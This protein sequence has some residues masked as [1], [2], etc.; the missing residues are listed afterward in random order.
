[1]ERRTLGRTGI[2]VS[3]AGLGCGGYSRLGMARGGTPGEAQAVVSEAL[4]L[5]INFFDTARAYGTEEVVGKAVAGCRESVVIS[6]KTLFRDRD[7]RYMPADRLVAS[8]E[9][10]LARLQ[11]DY[12]DVYSLHGVTPEHLDACL[13]QFVP[14]LQEQ[15]RL[16]KIRHLGVTESF[17]NDPAHEMLQRAIPTGLFDVVMVGFNFL[18]ASARESV[19]KLA[20][21]HG[22]GTQ[23]MHAVRRALVDLGTLAETLDKLVE[24][25]EIDA[26]RIN[27]ADPIDFLRD[28]EG[29]QSLTEAAYR[30][31]RHEPG[32]SVVL[33]GTGSRDHLRDNTAAINGAELPCN[34][35][36]KLQQVFSGVKSASGD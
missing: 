26:S 25:G 35:R 20:Q 23:V 36:Q 15:V 4:D 12:V 14:T 31:C 13:E 27:P 11:T 33:T 8:L 19:F 32:V 34:L 22:V 29:V 2:E 6:T 1:M 21:E 3:V 18:N 24:A 17:M 16:G 5:G 30:F 9:R 28:P 10:S 7:G